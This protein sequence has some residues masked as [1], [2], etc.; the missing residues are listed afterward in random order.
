M[1][2]SIGDFDLKPYGVTA[3]PEY[4]YRKVSHITSLDSCSALNATTAVPIYHNREFSPLP[5]R[6]VPLQF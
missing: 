6:R 4:Q 3:D 2:R 1:T 5:W